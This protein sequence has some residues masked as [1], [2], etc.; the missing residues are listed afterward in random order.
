MNRTLRNAAPKI[1]R[2]PTKPGNFEAKPC[3]P[4]MEPKQWKT[5]T[6]KKEMKEI[7]K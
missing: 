1:Q 4:S 3:R 5:N 7:E 6:K 2:N